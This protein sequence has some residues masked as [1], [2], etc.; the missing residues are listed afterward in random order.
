M[1]TEALFLGLL[2]CIADANG[3]RK[4]VC[5]IFKTSKTN[6]KHLIADHDVY[7]KLLID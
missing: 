5:R 7:L 2:I 3:Y 1:I 4:Y 6:G